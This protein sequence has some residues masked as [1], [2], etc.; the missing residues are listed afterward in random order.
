MHKLELL[1]FSGKL[2]KSVKSQTVRGKVL[3][4]C[5]VGEK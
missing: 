5:H 4:F 3:E 2:G 1:L